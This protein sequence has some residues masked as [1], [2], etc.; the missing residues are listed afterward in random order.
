MVLVPWCEAW[1]AVAEALRMLLYSETMEA[2]GSGVL[3]FWLA[4]WVVL[5]LRYF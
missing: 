5:V 2:E 1:K 4:G 3:V